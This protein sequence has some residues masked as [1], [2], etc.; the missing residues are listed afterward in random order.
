M[1]VAH[2]LVRGTSGLFY[3]RLRVPNDLQQALGAKLIKR[4]TGTRCARAAL[5]CALTLQARYAR[6]FDAIRRGE[7]MAKP[8]SIE[9]IR[10]NLREG[11]GSDY[12]IEQ[13]PGGLR[14][15]ATDQADHD[16]AM[17][18]LEHIGRVGPWPVAPVASPAPASLGKDMDEAIGMWV[19]TLPNETPGHR[20]NTNAQERKVREFY[21]WKLAKVG[22][23]FLVNSITRVE[24]AEFNVHNKLSTTKRGGAP[25]PRTIENKFLALIDFLNWAQTSTFYPAGD[26]P[27]TGH[28]NVRKKDRNRRAKT[29]GWQPF[30]AAQVQKI[31]DPDAYKT[32]RS[33]DARWLPVMALYTGARSN[34]L[35]HLEIEDCF[36]FLGQPIFDFNFLGPHKS[37]KSDA[38]ERK[39]P[40]H[41]DLIALGLWERVARLREAG[42]TKLFPGLSFTAENG[43]ANAGQSAFSRHLERLGITARGSGIVGLHSFRDTVVNTLTLAGVHKEVR[44]Q[45]VGHEVGEQD[46]HQVSYG[47]D[48]LP[49]GLAKHCH[50]PLSFGI[51]LEALRMLLR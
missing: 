18:A 1:R 13:G 34:E 17:L 25:A 27:A 6:V 33:E 31:F 46:D 39:T 37:L 4:A 42:E 43:P 49:A 41:P 21:A 10:A 44:K 48:L 7:H 22:G 29:H 28:A 40:V 30:S 16:R 47:I 51:D 14:I 50:P 32:M 26:N 19:S 15:E 38:S 24:C 3:V 5:V 12:V 45:Y 9:D 35:A 2:Y 8:P 23:P 11:R 20:K 36:D